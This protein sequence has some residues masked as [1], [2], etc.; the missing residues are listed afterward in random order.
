[1]GTR[2]E[3]LYFDIGHLGLTLLR[4]HHMSIIP[5]SFTK[6]SN[7]PKVL[8]FFFIHL[9][10]KKNTSQYV[11]NVSEMAARFKW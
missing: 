9:N 11:I 8:I 5:I 1:M 3:N 2:K 7:E 10:V 4:N 6:R